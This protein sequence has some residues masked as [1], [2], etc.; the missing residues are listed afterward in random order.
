MQAMPQPD[1]EQKELQALDSS[2]GVTSLVKKAKAGNRAALGRL[3][4]LFQEDI[5]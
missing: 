4:E 1:K 5:F 2:S 3:V